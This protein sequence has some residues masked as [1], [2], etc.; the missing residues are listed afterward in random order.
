[1]WLTLKLKIGLEL[2]PSVSCFLLIH[3]NSFNCVLWSKSD[4]KLPF[5]LG[6]CFVFFWDWKIGSIIVPVCIA[7]HLCSK[8]KRTSTTLDRF[9]YMNK[10]GF[11]YSS[12]TKGWGLAH[13]KLFHPSTTSAFIN[14]N[15]LSL[16]NVHVLFI[17]PFE[18]Q[19]NP[20]FKTLILAL[21]ISFRPRKKPRSQPP[22]HGF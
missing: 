8:S 1:M 14:S 4:G 12:C 9:F 11:G 15:Y 2:I 6:N 5:H 7:S 20:K 10:V 3:E 18:L 22:P 21:L 17:N 19:E 16:G 13:V